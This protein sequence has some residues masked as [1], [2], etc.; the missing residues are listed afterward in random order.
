MSNTIDRVRSV[1][2]PRFH[3][4]R[5]FMTDRP[6]YQFGYREMGAL[7]QRGHYLNTMR[8]MFAD[9]TFTAAQAL[10]YG[11]APGRGTLRF[12]PATRTNW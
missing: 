6:L 1:M 5:N 12:L 10:P 3:Y 11:R 8:R 2:G 4:I 7:Q 9:G